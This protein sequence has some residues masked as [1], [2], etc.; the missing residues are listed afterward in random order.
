[1]GGEVSEGGAVD[2]C[3][4][5]LFAEGGFVERGI[6]VANWDGGN[7]RVAIKY[8]YAIAS[9]APKYLHVQQHI[10]IR[11]SNVVSKALLVIDKHVQAS[12]IEHLV[13]IC[14]CLLALRARNGGLDSRSCGLIWEEWLLAGGW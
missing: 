9:E 12:G 6:A 11:I 13:Q 1:M 8:Q 5:H 14:N 4:C 7:L 2:E 3:G 10:S